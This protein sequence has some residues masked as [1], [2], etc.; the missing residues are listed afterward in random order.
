MDDNPDLIYE[1]R[2]WDP[3]YADELTREALERE[4]DIVTINP[5]QFQALERA[6]SEGDR[7]AAP[8]QQAEQDENALGLGEEA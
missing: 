4:G 8:T 3:E 7:S 1:G 6:A 5:G 2:G